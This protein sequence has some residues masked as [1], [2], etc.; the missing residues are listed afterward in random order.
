MQTEDPRIMICAL[1]GLPVTIAILLYYER[2][3]VTEKHLCAMLGKTDKT[4]SAAL[5]KLKEFGL[6]SRTSQGWVI[7]SASQLRL[8][9]ISEAVDNLWIKSRNFSDSPDSS[10]SSLNKNQSIESSEEEQ[11]PSTKSRNFSEQ[12][13][14][15]PNF[16]AIRKACLDAGIRDP[17]ASAIAKLPHTTPE[18]IAAHI[19]Q[20]EEEG[21]TIG[22]AIYRIESGW[23]PKPQ[24]KPEK[25]E[26]RSR[27]T[28]GQFGQYIQH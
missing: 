24:S 7:A 6:I 21:N 26:D 20:A 5:H 23:L 28:S 11:E 25:N 13:N 1:A 19:A 22:T 15:N 8:G 17:K 16:S 18:Y 9:E 4:V 2:Q 12:D 27:Y 14:S 10:C 3:P